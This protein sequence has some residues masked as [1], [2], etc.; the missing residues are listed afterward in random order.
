MQIGVDSQRAVDNKRVFVIDDNEVT[1][2][3]LQFMLADENETHE[4]AAIAPALAKALAWPPD[5][6][7]L[8]GGLLADAAL[9]EPLKGSARAPK[10]LLVCDEA[11]RHAAAATDIDGILLKPLRLEKVRSRVDAALGRAHALSIPVVMR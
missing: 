11:E 5:L 7:L 1:R 3:A 9:L 2:A 4:F 6:I 10:L 8:G